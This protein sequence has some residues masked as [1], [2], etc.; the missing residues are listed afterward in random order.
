MMR[1]DANPLGK[2]QKLSNGFLRVPATLT[3]TGVFTYRTGKDTVRRELRLPEEVFH[4]DALQSFALL[5]VTEEH[6][7]EPLTS[8]NA[9]KYQRGSVGE[10]ITQEGQFVNGTLMVTD[11]DLV[12]NMEHGN[13]RMVSCGYH[14]DLEWKSGEHE[15]EKY[16]CIQRNIRGNHVA[17]VAKGRAGPDVRVRLDADDAVMLTDAEEP[18]MVKYRIDG[19]EYEVS[20]QAAQAL[21][22]LRE[23]NAQTVKKLTDDAAA[24]TK[25]RDE[26]QAKCDAAE[27]KL[28]EA[29]KKAAPEAIL[30]AVKERVSL[31]RKAATVLGA[32]FKFDTLDDAAVVKAAV[33]KA[34]PD[35]KQ[36]G[37]S[38]DYLKARFDVA[39]ED[40]EKAAKNKGAV[41]KAVAG[42]R[43]G[44]LKEDGEKPNAEAARA[45]M[46]EEQRNA[47]KQKPTIGVTRQ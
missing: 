21:D 41:G 46:I 2:A 40:A 33:A 9:K 22:R 5:P 36:D 27:E 38:L 16:D 24:S 20:E 31:E 13:R 32:D 47:W 35:L 17:I 43:T 15:G 26:A 6:P 34:A 39:V 8:E 19:I 30:A 7:P 11:A 23:Q 29:A 42:A 4:P 45:K 25:A 28:K 1:Y 3:R 37:Y 12:K 44:E 14:C 10:S 18:Q